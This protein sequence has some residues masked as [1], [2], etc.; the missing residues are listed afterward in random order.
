MSISAVALNVVSV[1]GVWGIGL[2]VFLNGLGVP[3]IS[4]VMLPLGGVGVAQGRIGLWW[5]LLVAMVAQLVGVSAAYWLARTGGI[6]LIERYGRY[7]LISRRE[8]DAAQR[9][10]DKYGSPLVIF[11]AFIPGIQGF[12]GYIAGVARM[13]FGRFLVSVFIG[14]LVW[15][16]GLVYLGSIVGDHLDLIDR[17]IKQIGVI[18]LAAVVLLAI[19][20]VRR[21]RR[22]RRGELIED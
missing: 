9:S 7:V 21:H 16:G 15:I 14:K 12:I 3:G 10:F 2:G 8:L 11:G 5:L 19:W 17:S 1:L 4:E 20:Y 18:V 6:E 22:T 13:N